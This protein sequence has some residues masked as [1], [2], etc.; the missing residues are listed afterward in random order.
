MNRAI[1]RR[2]IN[3]Y[4]DGE[5]GLADKAELERIM[6]EN[7]DIRQ[8]YRELRRISLHL[9]S[10]SEVAVHPTRFR[11]RV[12]GALDSQERLYFTPQRAFAG[13]MLVAF[14]V[15]GLMFG[16][17]LYQQMLLGDKVIMASVE[18]DEL[19]S[20]ELGYSLSMEVPSTPEAFFNRLLL[21]SRVGMVSKSAVQPF[22][23]QTQL[24]EGARCIEGGGLNRVVFPNPLPYTMRIKTTPRQVL[25][26]GVVAEGLTGQESRIVARGSDGSTISFR[27]FIQLNGDQSGVTLIL[28]FK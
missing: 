16:L 20:G 12:L 8:E 4:L 2:W 17:M 24:F 7:P 23:N 10:I 6:A 9:G 14:L 25:T 3:E 26:L 21:E 18:T 11:M 5:I 13:A 22:V 19:L 15:V 1:I 28:N 27:E